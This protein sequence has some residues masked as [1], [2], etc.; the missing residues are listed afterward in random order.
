VKG[1]PDEL[2]GQWCIDIDRCLLGLT[3]QFQVLAGRRSRFVGRGKP[4][5]RHRLGV[6]KIRKSK[7]LFGACFALLCS[8]FF[9]GLPLDD[10][11]ALDS[12]VGPRIWAAR[13]HGNFL[14]F[15]F[16]NKGSPL[17]KKKPNS[18]KISLC[19]TK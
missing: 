10:L 13:Q 15:H 9:S 12:R 16:F 18:K 17:A 8:F 2:G 11:L 19:K 3:S 14:G 1:F 7:R 4:S 6:W 5:D